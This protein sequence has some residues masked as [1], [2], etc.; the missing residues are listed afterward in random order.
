M[1][2]ERESDREGERESQAVGRKLLG[3]EIRQPYTLTPTPNVLDRV[4][5]PGLKRPLQR[6]ARIRP[7]VAINLSPSTLRPPSH[8][9]G[10]FVGASQV[11]SWSHWCVIGAILWAF[12]AKS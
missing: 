3:D 6:F 7:H 4:Q 1:G 8:H 12:I 9:A 10:P 2:G 11:R 5:G